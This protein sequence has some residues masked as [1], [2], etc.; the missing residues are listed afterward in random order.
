MKL[1][2]V[3][4]VDGKEMHINRDR[5]DYITPQS[6][7]TV[8]VMLDD[9]TFLDLSEDGAAEVMAMTRPLTPPAPTGPQDELLKG[10]VDG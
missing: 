5:I 4:T 10:V 7:G 6:N 2:K 1:I 8:E 3:T 9:G